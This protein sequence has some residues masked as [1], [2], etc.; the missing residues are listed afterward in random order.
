MTLDEHQMQ[1]FPGFW[2]KQINEIKAGQIW[3]FFKISMLKNMG[4]FY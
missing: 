4:D 3:T 2:K 1:L